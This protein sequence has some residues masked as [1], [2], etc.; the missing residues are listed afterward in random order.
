MTH[1]NAAHRGARI[2]AVLVAVILGATAC[3]QSDNK[4]SSSAGVET[5][6]PDEKQATAGDAG[7][8]TP[9]ADPQSGP[10]GSGSEISNLPV[11]APPEPKNLAIDVSYGV[12]V[13]DI[14]KGIN[15][16]I[17]LADRHGGRIYERTI[18]IT[19]DRSAT[20][21]FV[22]KLPPEQVEAAIADLDAIG[23]Q[24]TASQ[25]TEDVTSQVV[26][27]DARLVTAQAS[28]DRVR[29]LLEAATDLGQILSLESQLT[30]RETLVEQYTAMKRALADRVSLA[31]LRVQLNLSP[32]AATTPAEPKPAHKPTIGSAFKTGWNGFVK[33][34]AAIL[35]FIGYTAPI[36]VIV[37]IGAAIVIP[38]S[39]RRRQLALERQSRSVAPPPPP[40]PVG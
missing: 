29:K 36:L 13:G 18:N 23:I 2:A 34:L 30:E 22:I 37:A 8:V 10:P 11:V 21:S 33:V 19:D 1:V 20:A 32:D 26:N 3:S 25:G 16:V 27:I 40:T 4:A 31:T 39:R 14:S 12:E 24:R 15:D 17:A 9:A 7:R 38:I 35:I 5:A 28:L 6:S